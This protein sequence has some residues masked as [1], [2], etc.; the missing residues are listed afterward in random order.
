MYVVTA[1]EKTGIDIPYNNKELVRCVY[2]KF[3]K[4]L[5]FSPSS[6]KIAFTVRDP[7][8]TGIYRVGDPRGFAQ[9]CVCNLSGH[10]L[11]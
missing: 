7:V 8:H 1:Q 11:I 9:R 4:S 3:N 2:S 10:W 6:P 5:Y